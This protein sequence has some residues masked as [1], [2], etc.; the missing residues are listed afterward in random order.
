MSSATTT[1]EEAVP[2]ATSTISSTKENE[3]F[4]TNDQP[5]SARANEV[6]NAEEKAAKEKVDVTTLQT[7]LTDLEDKLSKLKEESKKDSYKELVTKTKKVVEDH[8]VTKET[9]DKQL[10]LVKTA[11][12]EVEEAIKK[13]AEQAKEEQPKEESPTPKKRGRRGAETPAPKEEPK[14][15]P[16]YTNGAGDTGTYALA[17]EMRKIVKYLKDNGADAAKVAAI[18]DNYD[19]L[20]EKLGLTDGNAVLSEADFAAATANLKAARDFTEAFLRKQDEN[21]QPLNAQPAV[22]GTERSVGGGLNRQARETGRNFQDSREYY[23]EDGKTGISPYSKYTYVFHNY[24]PTNIL[25]FEHQPISNAE[26]YIHARV[27]PTDNGF[28]WTISVNS[29]RFSNTTNDS[30]WFTIPKGQTYKAGTARVDAQSLQGSTPYYGDG[31]IEGA[32]RQAGLRAVNRGANLKGVVR[33]G[34]VG[35]NA[36]WTDDFKSLATQSVNALTDKGLYLP[37]LAQDSEKQLAQAKF[38]KINKKGGDLFY[39]E[40]PDNVFKYTITFETEGA[41]NDPDKNDPEELVYAAG[42]KGVTRGDKVYRVLVNQW[43]AVTDSELRDIDR[44]RM[45]LKNGGTFIVEQGKY[46]NKLWP[47]AD[48]LGPK[49]WY[50]SKN[51]NSDIKKVDGI[52]T[53]GD[54]SNFTAIDFFSYVNYK[55][56]DG[57]D[58]EGMKFEANNHGQKFTFY[59][60]DGTEIT[61]KQ[62]GAEA[63]G[64]PGEHV[65]YY[66]RVF[67]SDGSS[68]NGKFRFLVKPN[69]PVFN[70][71]MKLAGDKQILTASGG[72]KDIPMTLFREYTDATGTHVVPV[73]TKKADNNGTVTFNGENNGGVTL[74]KGK[75][76]VRTVINT[77]SYKDYSGKTQTTLE[78]DPATEDKKFEVVEPPVVKINGKK[79]TENAEDNQFIIYK[80][81]NFNPTFQVENDGKQVN[82]LKATNI[83]NG[84]WFNNV[85]GRDQEKTNM[86]SGS[87]FTLANNTVDNIAKNGEAT[88]TV[89]NHN[90]QEK[91][92]KFKYIIAD[93]QPKDTPK[94]KLV[95]ET[96]GDPHSFVKAVVNGNEGDQYFPGGMSFTWETNNNQAPGNNTVLGEAG[97][98]T[99]YN[100]KVTFPANGPYEKTIDNVRYTI[101]GPSP[102]K[103]PVTFNVTDNVAPTVKMTNPADNA[104]VTL[105]ENE[106]APST[107][108]IFRG[109]TLNIPLSM[110]DNDTRG[111][112]NLKYESGLP[113]G[114]TLNG[115]PTISK[116]GA[117]ETNQGT[118]TINGKVAANAEL[119][120]KTV[121]FKVSDDQGGNVNSGNKATLKFKVEVVDLDFEEGKGE[122]RND[123]TLVVK[124]NKGISLNDSNT[125][126]RTTNGTVN[127]DG[128]FPSDMKFRFIQSDGT[129][130]NNVTFN[131]PG[132]HQVKAAAY[133]PVNNTSTNGVE[134]V[135]ARGVTGD[136]VSE[137]VNRS[138]L[139]KNIEVQIKPTAPTITP[140]NGDVTITPATE[141]NVNKFEFKYTNNNNNPT[142]Q[143]VTATKVN[144]RWTLS[145]QPTDGVTINENTGVVTIKDREV[146]DATSVTAKAVTT[147]ATGSLESDVNTATTNAGERELPKFTFDETNTTVENGVRTVY[148]TPTESNNFKLGTFSDN[149]N[150]L[151][152]ARIS[153]KNNVGN[154]LDFGLS[155]SEKFTRTPNTEKEGSR[156]II[157]TG[158]LDKTN[159]GAKWTNNFV[160]VNRYAV[161]TD[162]A[163]NELRDQ[164]DSTTNKTRMIFK[165][166]TQAEKYNPTASK[167]LINKDVTA[168]G[169]TISEAEFNTMKSNLNLKFTANRGGVKVNGTTPDLN[170]AMKPGGAVKKK[171]DGTYY[172]GATITYPD[173]STE[174]IEIPVDK[175]DKEAPK[176]KLNGVELKDNIDENPKFVV[177]R[178]AKFN[179]TLE[180]SDNA[181]PTI[182]LKA[183]NLP[184]GREFIKNESMRNG[185]QVEINRDNI[186]PNDAQLGEREGKILVKDAL[187]NEKEYKFKYIVADVEV[188]N[189]PETVNKGT[190]LFVPNNTRESK[191][192]HYYVKAVVSPNTDGSDVYY[193]GGMNFKWSKNNAEV[194]SETVFNTPGTITYNAVVKFPNAKSVKNNVDIDGDG[195]NE[196]VT[197]YAPDKVERTVTFRVK[198]TAPTIAP[199]TNG[200]VTITPANETNVN[201]LNF[202]YVHPNGSTQN[203]TA[204]RNG[205]IWSLSNNTPQD[206]VTINEN[207]G[208]VTIKDRAVKDN[209]TVTAK[210]VTADSASADRVESDITNSTSPAGDTERPKFVFNENGKETKVEN[211]D[212]VVYVTPTETTDI[213]IGSV[214]DNSNKLLKVEMSSTISE[215][216][217]ITFEGVANRTDNVELDAPRKVTLRGV[218]P[219][220]NG[221]R[222]WVGN[223]V[224]TRNV[225]AQDAA[226]LTTE[227]SAANTVK[228]KVLIQKDK[229]TPN[230]VAPVIE[231]DITQPNTSLTDEEFNKI[232]NSLTFTAD[233]GS[234]KIDKNT[235]NLTFTSDKVVKVKDDGSYYVSATVIYPD[236]SSETV[237][238]PVD[239]KQANKSRTTLTAQEVSIKAAKDKNAQGVVPSIESNRVISNITIPNNQPQPRT[240]VLKDNG[241]ITEVD[242]KKVAT[243]VLTYSDKS[244]KEVTVPVLEVKPI[245]ITTT[246]NELDN[247]VTVKPN[248]TVENGDK[249]H[250]TIRGVGMQLTKT[251]TGYTNSRNDRDITVNQDGSITISLLRNE[252]FQAGDRVVTRHESNKNGKV[253]SY[254]TEAFAG[255][256][257]V[258]KVPAINLTNLTPKEIEDVKAAVKKANPSVNVDEL[259]VAANGDVT[260]THRGEGV[261]ENDPAQTFTLNDN[262]RPANN[263]ERYT[264]T[265]IPQTVDNGTVPEAESSVNKTGLPSGTTVSWKT[266][267]TV[268]TPGQT[269]GTAI[270]H[271]PDG[272]EEEVEVPITVK[273]QKDTY[274]P[275]AIP[276]TVDNGT[277]PEAESSVNKTGLPS[278]TTVS[279]KTP[280]TVTTPGQTTG[281]A[282]VHY[283]DGSEEEV[284][285]PITVKEQNIN[286]EPEVLPEIPEYTDPI[287][288]SDVDE[289][290]N[291]I[292]PPVVEN[293]EFNGGVNGEL[294]E[295]VESPKVKLIITKWTDE[296]GNELKPADA[297][298]PAVPGEA[299]EAFEAGE[300]EGY[301]FVRTEDKGDVVTHIFRKVTSTKPEGNGER[302]DG[303]NKPQPTP[304]V[305]TDNTERK[306][307]VVTPDEQPA[308]TENTTTKPKA[309]QNILPN[310]GTADGLGIFSVAAASILAGLGLIIPVKKEDEETQNN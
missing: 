172:V 217:G 81:A 183:H 265:A 202:T 309:S 274:T 175:S 116:T 276:Q 228:F 60:E 279:W 105:S 310:T 300:I 113:S 65:F 126:L 85:N 32:M 100:A 221:T 91:V 111:K 98:I 107:I 33:Y 253:D 96:L 84:V 47:Y 268:T 177:F 7:A 269:T 56:R 144:N 282:I 10:E 117:V 26:K 191:D 115:G 6:D 4:S 167:Q 297:K 46:Y 125:Y 35:A 41:P 169:A 173:L 77:D 178:G 246:F 187:N 257:P 303:D 42:F 254:E 285:V 21:G 305:P 299:N 120:I 281:T 181:N 214:T 295:P 63:G 16:T 196:N 174:D 247:T 248:T 168:P 225:R 28:L 234:V 12:K 87:T 280:P 17:E 59:R 203:I 186:V 185:T 229:Y 129:L 142:V 53:A 216:G 219:S 231:K 161:A 291:L 163:G 184:T 199:Q 15:L 249:L 101:Y 195:R 48:A 147:D 62:L 20:N 78:S 283:P 267:P 208:V 241:R 49:G 223:E 9:A 39:F 1:P 233:K 255:L 143:T 66:K 30:Y 200:D 150:K 70:P 222:N 34:K 55:L 94:D 73:E 114:V 72:T 302:Q 22:P 108:R 263:A 288:T 289:N 224:Y 122:I 71:T 205:N 256:K 159:K 277:V 43:H 139:Y 286:G 31:T 271:Y 106:S 90:N 207:T 13:E 232:K 308:E 152:E 24:R 238:V 212:Q 260:Y 99:N 237:E 3:A 14:A 270:V 131:T 236:G 242:G 80:G 264:P 38:D 190:K 273:E 258:E 240:K 40:Q 27:T 304:G 29:G 64:T 149:S 103:I 76:F 89:R 145:G 19:K 88:V 11:I 209:Q 158:T 57:K 74:E 201:T 189:T 2:S 136:N 146:K 58:F 68:D 166:L 153:E 119:G 211:G 262:V 102:K 25:D 162:A 245:D 272:S 226:T 250:V 110:Y 165:V 54:Q 148:V 220:K 140:A 275:T 160:V 171:S 301:V 135:P 82:Y 104:T 137:V 278:G 235:Q 36:Y 44:Y 164:T 155:Y 251:A 157:I 179:P 50:G 296:Q 118:A 121:T 61:T 138:Y 86:A 51:L 294:P 23:F 215:F 8:E 188:K 75:Y 109:A 293:L 130:K 210:S 83:P 18:K 124:G 243:V 45:T 252:A 93:V 176:V 151:I 37:T 170:V 92:Y 193:P 79:L 134:K 194:T 5:A 52:I 132:K 206:G 128:F 290:G 227:D 180:V 133:F 141:D 213:E 298:A 284:E 307:E 244:T 287:G 95:G 156:D 154:D 259:Q 197:I 192:S 218:I 239:A 204:T 266:P 182:Y 306:P 69:N 67:T 198:P 127:N 261:G 123:G 230:T 292:D 112:V 97:R